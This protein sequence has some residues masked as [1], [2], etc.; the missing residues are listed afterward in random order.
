MTSSL[1]AAELVDQ[2]RALE[3]DI[4]E[5][6]KHGL[7]G[8]EKV[9]KEFLDL[10]LPVASEI[11]DLAADSGIVS[12]RI[13]TRGYVN[14]D[15]LDE[16]KNT[17]DRLRMLRLY[18]NYI[19]R[20]VHGINSTGLRE[21]SYDVIITAGG[22]A[23]DA[24][25]PNDINELLRILKEGGLL[26]WTQH[27]AQDEGTSEFGLFEGNLRNLERDGQ[28]IVMKAERFEDF[29]S[30]TEGVFYMVKRCPK[31]LPDFAMKDLP[32]EFNDQITKIMV[33]DS[34]PHNNIKFYD[35]WS[36]RYDADLVMV[37][38]YTGH[39]KCV[40]AFLKLGLDRNTYILDLAAGTGLLGA[41]VTKH[42]YVMVDALDASLGMLGQARKQNIYK[43]YIHASVDDIGSIP[44]N[45]ESYDVILSSSGFAPGQIYPS[46]F[47]ELL[48]I[49]RPG[50]YLLWTM[51]DGYQHT[52]QRF[53]MLDESINDLVHNGFAELIVGPVVF[54][55]FL[56][57][58]SGRFYIMRKPAKHHWALGTPL[59]SPQNSPRSSP[60]MARKAK[61]RTPIDKLNYQY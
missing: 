20:S 56:L 11:L 42:G 21:E 31:N 32:T 47:P 7:Q 39:T 37:G 59:A 29:R 6:H 34:S 2:L 50:G 48:R 46:A 9:T 45:N 53:A 13:Q 17:I 1:T 8:V 52:S 54:H 24:I 4:K 57:E 51:R 43:N 16:D 23:H 58:H 14:V 44:V 33:D 12:A 55:N 26:L 49:M 28:C 35:Q 5:R 41:E 25:N 60:R 40:D 22:F 30:G 61:L 36:D 19:C 18:R 15:A 38:N 10:R 3:I 27:T